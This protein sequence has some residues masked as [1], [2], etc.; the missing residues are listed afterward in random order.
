MLAENYEQ[1]RHIFFESYIYERNILSKKDQQKQLYHTCLACYTD[2]EYNQIDKNNY[3]L[4]ETKFLRH[5]AFRNKFSCRRI[6]INIL[7]TALCFDSYSIQEEILMNQGDSKLLYY[8]FL[9]FCSSQ[10]PTLM[11]HHF[12]E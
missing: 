1:L 4:L 2:Q 6:T 7:I 12:L 8:I 11:F 5:K 3:Q 10:E 9:D